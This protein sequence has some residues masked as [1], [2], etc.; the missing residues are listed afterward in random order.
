VLVSR[1]LPG[2]TLALLASCSSTGSVAPPSVVGEWREVTDASLASQFMFFNADG[3]CG[4]GGE[5]IGGQTYCTPGTYRYENGSVYI[6][7]LS[8][9]STVNI[10]ITLR[11]DTLTLQGLNDEL[12]VYTREN[13]LPANRCP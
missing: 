11:N 10:P 7:T 4:E 13:A 3:T 6:T 12:V 1:A 5:A 8:P 9:N 2:V